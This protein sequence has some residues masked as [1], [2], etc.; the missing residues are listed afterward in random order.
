MTFWHL[1]WEWGWKMVRKSGAGAVLDGAAVVRAATGPGGADPRSGFS[2]EQRGG[3]VK[4]RWKEVA[5]R[6]RKAIILGTFYHF[7]RKIS[8]GG[9]G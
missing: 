4:V 3:A 9:D 2:C 7:L 1:I 6:R 8:G 5:K